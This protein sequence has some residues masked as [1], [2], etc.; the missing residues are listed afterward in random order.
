MR[1]ELFPR[2]KR[3]PY[4]WRDGFTLIELLV[5][6]AVIG[7]LAG[8]LVPAVQEIR[9]SARRIQCR[10]NLRQLGLAIHNYVEAN[11]VLPPSICYSPNNPQQIMGAWGIHARLLPFLDESN[12]YQQIQL[13]FAWNDPVNQA[14]GIPQMQIPGLNCPS[15]PLGGTVHYS[16]PGEGYTFPTNYAYNFGT[17]LIFDPVTNTGGDGGFFPNSRISFADITDGLSHTL[18]VAEV[19]TYQAYII[20][21]SN[22]GPTPPGDSSV[23]ASFANGADM[24]LGANPDDNEGHT[25]WC[26]GPS[27]ETGFTTAFLPNQFVP[28]WPNFGRKYDIDW[29]TRY[30]GTSLTQATYAA[31]TVRSYH[32]GIVQVLMM[33]GSVRSESQGLDLAVWRGL[34]TRN[35]GENTN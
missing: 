30:E 3:P 31:V 5:V 12:I 1:K 2:S 26:D 20:N 23:P 32:R 14:T 22:P 19:K 27:H 10:N 13:S 11:R 28:Y 7:I 18:C 25:E 6:L 35:G 21:T 24:S 34:G 33:D 8:L 4:Q 15:D 9:E 16:G 17:W 29:S